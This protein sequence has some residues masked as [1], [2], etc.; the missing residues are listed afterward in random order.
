VLE[1]A[2][3]R[4]SMMKNGSILPFA[5][6]LDVLFISLRPRA[7]RCAPK[8]QLW[9]S[10]RPVLWRNP[11]RSPFAGAARAQSSGRR[12]RGEWRPRN[13]SAKAPVSEM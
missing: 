1:R 13:S 3:A 8:N 12:F 9:G 11:K 10:F 7:C 5:W 2:D 4:F 6:S